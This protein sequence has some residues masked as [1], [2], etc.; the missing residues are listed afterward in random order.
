MH[1]KVLWESL[2]EQNRQSLSSIK[3]KIRQ[4]TQNPHLS[5][6]MHSRKATK[7]KKAKV[8]KGKR[9]DVTSMRLVVSYKIDRFPL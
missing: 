1:T 3:S 6:P 5:P 9:L 8:D 2:K 7:S 4:H